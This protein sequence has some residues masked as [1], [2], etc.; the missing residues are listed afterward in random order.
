MIKNINPGSASSLDP[1][2]NTVAFLKAGL[3]IFFIAKD[4]TNGYEL[5]KTDGTEVNTLLVKNIYSGD[6]K[7]YLGLEY[8]NQLYFI[9]TNPTNSYWELWKSD[10]TS[11]GT[12]QVD[13]GPLYHNQLFILN[14]ELIYSKQSELW[15]TNEVSK[16]L[17]KSNFQSYSS[18][19]IF[20]NKFYFTGE[21]KQTTEGLELWQSDGTPSGTV[22]FK[23]IAAGKNQFDLQSS[24]P[25]NY[26]LA[27][28]LLFFIA[29]DAMH[30]NELWKSD[31]TLQN[32]NLVKDIYQNG[33]K[34][35][36]P[37]TLA[38]H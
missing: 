13:Q 12:T 7:G 24:S 8:N 21:S 28:N 30:G 38:P 29:N 14:N 37:S 20:D 11:A 17:L 19:I 25:I 36:S 26:F 5:W 6:T 4:A 1:N 18:G 34:S 3:N 15:K 32:T 22:L 9:P 35:S 31:G 23:N 33:N 2:Q 16:T 10:G 27:N